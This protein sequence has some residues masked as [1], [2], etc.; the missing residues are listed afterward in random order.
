M[1]MRPLRIFTIFTVLSGSMY[2]VADDIQTTPPTSLANGSMVVMRSAKTDATR[3]LVHFHGDAETVKHAFARSKLNAI[4]VVVNFP[5][6]ST[7]YS[8]PFASDP[9]LFELIQA[10]AKS[11]IANST[12]AKDVRWEHV[13]LSSFSAGYGAVREILKTPKY[14][15]QINCIVAADSIYAGLQQKEPKRE[16]DE[17]N[18]RDFLRFA[19]LAAQNKKRFVLSHSSQATPYASTTETANYLLASLH[20]MRNPVDTHLTESMWQTSQAERG[21]FQVLGFDG[22]TGKDHMQ[23]LHHIDLLWRRLIH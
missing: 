1:N 4:L 16:V 5:G 18:M 17:T 3:L 23:H 22:T 15:E 20:L 21:Q 2:S 13:M 19:S 10:R 6:L 9:Q 7:A 8:K 12:P 14:F 11:A